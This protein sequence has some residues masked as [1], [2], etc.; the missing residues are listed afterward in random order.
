M[1]IDRQ[2][3]AKS[4]QKLRFNSVNSEIIGRKFTKFVLD[5]CYLIF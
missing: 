2:I 4:R 5:Y 3:A 1:K